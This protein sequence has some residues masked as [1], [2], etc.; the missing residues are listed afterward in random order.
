[1]KRCLFLAITLLVLQ[2]GNVTA[3]TLNKWLSGQVRAE[4]HLLADALSYTGGHSL[5]LLKDSRTYVPF[6]LEPPRNSAFVSAEQKASFDA[7]IKDT[8]SS[9]LPGG[10]IFRLR[11]NSAPPLYATSAGEWSGNTWHS[12]VLA[13]DF[14]IESDRVWDGSG[15]DFL[16]ATLLAG[17]PPR[18]IVYDQRGEIKREDVFDVSAPDLEQ[19]VEATAKTY[20]RNRRPVLELL[21]LAEYLE[22]PDTPWRAAETSGQFNLR[23]QE[24]RDEERKMLK[25]VKPLSRNAALEALQQR[26]P[27]QMPPPSA[28]PTTMPHLSQ[29]PLPTPPASP[30]KAE[31]P[32]P[33]EAP[34]NMAWLYSLAA[35]I[36]AGLGLVAYRNRKR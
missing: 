25:F 17:V 16:Y 2:A 32:T 28:K 18:L 10:Y 3:E 19:R 11:F 7:W 31:L 22:N 27:Q 24:Q 5:D 12:L 36:L 9:F 35:I 6:F 23:N 30:A 14:T 13:K 15:G 20:S 26:A 34:S 1:M 4:E 33:K 8:P 29:T 21:S